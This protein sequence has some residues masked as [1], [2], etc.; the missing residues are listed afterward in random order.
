MLK[1]VSLPPPPRR[2]ATVGC[3]I[4]GVCGLYGF[5]MGAPYKVVGAEDVSRDVEA[6]GG[7]T[8]DAKRLQREQSGRG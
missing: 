1:T 2:W 7:G 5:M 8:T 4:L 3:S 6:R